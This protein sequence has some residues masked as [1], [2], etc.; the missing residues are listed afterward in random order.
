M[1]N[2]KTKTKDT[3]RNQKYILQR[4]ERGLVEEVATL[5][6]MFRRSTVEMLNTII[7]FGLSKW[8]TTK[9]CNGCLNKQEK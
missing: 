4:I 7:A 8:S 2:K 1:K 6:P 9:A 5:A 3:A